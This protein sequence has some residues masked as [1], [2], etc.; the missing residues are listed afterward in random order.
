[1]INNTSCDT[2]FIVTIPVYKV[3]LNIARP[4]STLYVQSRVIHYDHFLISWCLK[5]VKEEMIIRQWIYRLW[6]WF[7]RERGEVARPRKEIEG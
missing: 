7:P 5:R 1:M 2:T 4:Y 6:L 3:T